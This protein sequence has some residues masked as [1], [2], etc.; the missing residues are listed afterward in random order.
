VVAA[1]PGSSIRG[2]G[3]EGV[4]GG[5]FRLGGRGTPMARLQSMKDRGVRIVVGAAAAGIAALA[6]PTPIAATASPDAPGPVPGLAPVDTA[7]NPAEAPAPE[8]RVRLEPRVLPELEVAGQSVRGRLVPGDLPDGSLLLERGRF[9]SLPD[10]PGAVETT[11]LRNNNRGQT[12]GAYG[13][14]DPDGAPRSRGFLMR[15]RD[16]TRIDVPGALVTLPLGINDR[17]Q[18]VGSWVGRDATVNPATGELNPGHGFVWDRGRVRTFDVPGATNTAAYEINNRGQIVGNYTDG[19]GVQHGYVLHDGKVT[20]IDHPRAS[21]TPNLTGTRVVGIDDRGRLVGGYGDDAGSIHAWA[22][23]DGRFTDVTPPGGLQAEASEIDNRGRIVGRY[24]DATPKLRS[25][26]LERGRYT[27][28]DVP[29][30]C[31]T[32]AFGLNERDQIVIASAGTTDGTTCPS[33]RGE[34]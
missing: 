30:R 10:V 15:G 26:L 9:R 13:E 29:G 22:W 3:A 2:G 16:F 18:V 4:D 8:G 11:H 25:F 20:S 27:R 5:P 19:N 7:D 17:G 14:L 32:A 6:L 31:D 33:P 34:T 28:I 24:L 23:T 1:R 12:V 21:D